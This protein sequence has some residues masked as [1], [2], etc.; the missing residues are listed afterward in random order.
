MA[1][2]SLQSATSGSPTRLCPAERQIGAPPPHT[3]EHASGCPF[4]MPTKTSLK[5]R[6]NTRKEEPS[7]RR[8]AFAKPRLAWDALLLLALLF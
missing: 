2:P 6:S 3:Y 8:S 7:R 5:T 4:E 1:G